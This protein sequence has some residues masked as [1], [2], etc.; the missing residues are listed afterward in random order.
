MLRSFTK[1]II[2]SFR[3]STG[4]RLRDVR[5]IACDLDGTLLNMDDMVAPTTAVMV[6]KIEGMGIPFVF[7]S[8]RHYHA[9]EPYSDELRMTTPI[10]SLDGGSTRV[11]HAETPINL[12]LFDQDFALDIIDEILQTEGVACCAVTPDVFLMSEPDI[13][14]PSHHHH[15]NI[16][17]AVVRDYA[18]AVGGI[19]EI[20]ASGSF[21]G[22]NSVLAYIEEKAKP[23]ELKIRMFES[24]SKSDHWYLEVRDAR[25]TKQ[26]ALE[27]LTETLGISMDDVVGIGDHYNDLDFCEKV[28][29]VV[30][31]QNGVKE[32]KDIANFVTK[33]DCTHEGIDEFLSYFLQERGGGSLEASAE[34]QAEASRR[35]RSR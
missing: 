22:V 19:L 18:P 12:M 14:L 23:D 6:R 29:Y 3:R 21:Y 11:P 13:N 35:K 5:L 28:G 16:E 4:D 10:I 33:K 7:I 15:W 17:T 30:A 1:K 26:R 25:A 24:H 2:P 31:M 8:R 9:V 27:H 20:I 34:E 32:L